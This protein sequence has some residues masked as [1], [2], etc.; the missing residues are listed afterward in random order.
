LNFFDILVIAVGLAMDAFAVSIATGLSLEKVTSR[1]TF[2][3]AFHFG[4]FQCLMPIVGWYAGSYLAGYIER[5]DHWVAFGLLAFV[6]GKMLWESR[7]LKEDRSAADPTRGMMLMTLSLATS[8][9]ALAV[10]LSMAF[11]GVSVWMPA[12]VIGVITA[13]LSTVGIV[14]GGR[15]GSRFSHWAEAG[16]GIV[17]ILIGLK[18]LLTH[19]GFM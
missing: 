14:F 12:V 9:D 15:I 6:G 16:G 17:L 3:M 2:R 10:G 19:T 8:I 7:Q 11:S 4:L 13:L 5:Y 18:I 1:H